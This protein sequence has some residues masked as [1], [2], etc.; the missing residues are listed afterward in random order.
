[1]SHSA[2]DEERRRLGLDQRITRRDFVNGALVGAGGMLLKTGVAD[3]ATA[4]PDRF[5]GYG[6]VG[7][8]ATCNGNTWPVVQAAH[9]IR[10]G[11]Y[12]AKALAGA[13]TVGDFDLVVVGGGLAGLSAAHYFRKATSRDA[14]I[15]L[16]ENHSM[17]GG[18]ARQ[19]EFMVGGERLLAPQGSNL[20]SIPKSG[21]GSLAD[22]FFAEFGIPRT[23]QWQ[24]WDPSLK[25]IRFVRDNASN[26]DGFQEQQFD[27]GYF[28]ANG[29][30]GSYCARNIWSNGLK[31]TPYSERARRDLIRWRTDIGELSE[32]EKRRLDLMSFKDYLEKDRGYD[33][34][35]TRFLEPVVGDLCGVS[36]DAMSAR[37]GRSMVESSDVT[38]YASFPGG[39]TP[40]ARALLRAL[41]PDAL[42]GRDFESLMYGKVNFPTLDRAGQ[43]TRV[44][45][46]STVLRVEHTPRGADR[47]EVTYEKGGTLFKARGR[48]VVMASG[49][50]VNKHIL[51]DM[52]EDLRAA[53]QQF[54]YAPA[55]IVNVALR[56]WR[57]LYDLGVSACRWSAEPD[58]F[59]WVCNVRQLMVGDGRTPP[60]HP[61]KPIVLTFYTGMPIPG[62]PAAVQGAAA[63]GQLLGTSYA[64]LEVRVRRQMVRLFGEHG[65]KPDRDIAGIIV[66]R[67]GHARLVQPPGFY[68]GTG[69]KLSPL[70][71]VRE[72]YDRIAIGHS[73]LN[74]SQH[75]DSA[76]FYGKKAA[77][78]AV[79]AI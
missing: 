65:F 78:R 11:V 63:R 27:I 50:W 51:G 14:R 9:R 24:P 70:E 18:E 42:P 45:L 12:D 73:E 13:D 46:E 16:L 35:V 7:D 25:P 69:G 37:L 34:A 72:G 55:V 33:P 39:N 2:D 30:G 62:L 61:D 28:F 75:W 6:G 10:D 1:M 32:S 19:N 21:D 3:S 20:F 57:F 66:N 56:Q 54:C 79:A 41:L 44:R 77:E 4:T 8:Y 5:T 36:P 47:V 71:R 64:D 40:F 26:M 53:Y 29:N 67:W 38:G 43:G 17:V 23:Y 49:G 74:G 58:G 15:L 48:A 52:P 68:Y 76:V 22:A 31:D 59:G 60:L